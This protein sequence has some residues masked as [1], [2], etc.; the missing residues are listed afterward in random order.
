MYYSL[1]IAR[2]CLRNEGTSF[3]TFSRK[4]KEHYDNMPM[5]YTAILK[6]VKTVLFR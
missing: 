6:A 2:T 3:C 5:Q 1:Y 4:E